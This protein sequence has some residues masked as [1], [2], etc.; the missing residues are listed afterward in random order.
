MKT[1]STHINSGRP[2]SELLSSLLGVGTG[3]RLLLA[4]IA[5]HDKLTGERRRGERGEGGAETEAS[6]APQVT[7]DQTMIA[8]G[9]S[10]SV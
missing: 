6:D 9:T 4:V 1:V 7:C 10:V 5:C 2:L 3:I 8:N